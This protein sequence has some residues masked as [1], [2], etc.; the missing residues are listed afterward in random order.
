MGTWP[1]VHHSKVHSELFLWLYCTAAQPF[2]FTVLKWLTLG[3]DEWA[4]TDVH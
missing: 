3:V 1:R 2:V 4:F